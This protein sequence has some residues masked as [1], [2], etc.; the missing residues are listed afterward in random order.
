MPRLT[1]GLRDPLEGS[2]KWSLDWVFAEAERGRLV[3]VPSAVGGQAVWIPGSLVEWKG[4]GSSVATDRP[5][6]AAV[7]SVGRRELMPGSGHVCLG[8]RETNVSHEIGAAVIKTREALAAGAV[9]CRE[10]EDGRL[11]VSQQG[12]LEPVS[13]LSQRLGGYATREYYCA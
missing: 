9:S 10:V 7:T 1:G 8:A 4:Q 13:Q 3:G 5:G 12:C 6:R 2:S 11:G